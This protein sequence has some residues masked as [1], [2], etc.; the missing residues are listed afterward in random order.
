MQ[1]VP[2]NNSLRHFLVKLTTVSCKIRNQTFYKK[3]DKT[4]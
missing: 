2:F 3:A 1:K 4:K